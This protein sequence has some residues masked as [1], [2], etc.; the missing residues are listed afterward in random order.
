LPITAIRLGIE[1][2][3]CHRGEDA[4]SSPASGRGTTSNVPRESSVFDSD[5]NPL[6]SAENDGWRLRGIVGL[7][8][9]RIFEFNSSIRRSYNSAINTDPLV[10]FS[11]NPVSNTGRLRTGQK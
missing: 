7:Q 5:I 11:F 9:C 8:D 3:A 1:G 6:C 10:E 4:A 2:L